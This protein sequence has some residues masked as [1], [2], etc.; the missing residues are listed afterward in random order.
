MSEAR[1]GCHEL[2]M[3]RERVVAFL[4]RG[5][6]GK[7]TCLV[8]TCV[9]LTALY[10]GVVET[11]QGN[12]GRYNVCTQSLAQPLQGSTFRKQIQEAADGSETT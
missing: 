8:E 5:R 10:R 1:E 3:T 4:E 7:E 9:A 6:E 2:V 12:E 11:E